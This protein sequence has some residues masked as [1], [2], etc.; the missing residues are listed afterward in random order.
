MPFYMA[1]VALLYTGG[2]MMKPLPRVTLPCGATVTLSS[3]MQCAVFTA[4]AVGVGDRI[5]FITRRP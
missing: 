2:S 3:T 4:G 5:L 1:M